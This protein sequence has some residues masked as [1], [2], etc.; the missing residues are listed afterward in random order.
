MSFRSASGTNSLIFGARAFGAL[1][2]PDGAH[3]G[4]RADRQ[5]QTLANGEH[6]GDGRGRDGAKADEQ[7]AK[8]AACGRYR[9]V[10]KSQSATIS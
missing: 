6:A 5:R 4:Q 8:L 10:V 1:A 3:L 7:H 9:P 2:E